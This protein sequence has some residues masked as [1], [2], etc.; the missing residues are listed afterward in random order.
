MASWPCP[1][2]SEV[3]TYLGL[4]AT[5]EKAALL[6][7]CVPCCPGPNLSRSGTVGSPGAGSDAHPHLNKTGRQKYSAVFP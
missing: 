5:L 7:G 3:R 1:A 4:F 6:R 2:N